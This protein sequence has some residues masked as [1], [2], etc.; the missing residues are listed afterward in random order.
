ML[1]RLSAF[2]VPLLGAASFVQTA[3]AFE[4]ETV[5]T[6]ARDAAASPYSAPAPV[7]RFMRDLSYND[8]QGIRFRTES[9]L[10]RDSESKF[11]VMMV[12]PGLFYT[13][14][15]RINIIEQGEAEPLQFEKSQ[16]DYPNPEIEK[17]VP[18]DLGYAGLKVTFPFDA[19]DV[20][21]Q[22][23]V[24]AGA[25]YFRAVGK[26]NNFGISG[27]GVAVDT[28]LPSGEE[29]PAFVEFWLEKPEPG[30]ETFRLYGLLDGESLTGAYQFTV[31]PGET[32]E[33][34]VKSVIFPRRSIELLGL[35][36]LT[37]MF[38]YGENMLQPPGEWRPEVHDSDGLLI[39]DG[40]SDEWLWRPL[41]NPETLNTDYFATQNVRG[42]GLIQRDTEFDSYMDAEAYYHS[43]PSAWVEP[44]GDWGRGD[45]VLVQLPTPDETNDNIVS[46]WRTN[47]AIRPEQSLH[48]NYKVRFGGQH[49]AGET[50]ARA[51]DTYL[52]D[53]SRIGGGAEAGAVRIIVDFADGPLA[54]RDPGAA[55]VADVSGLNDT[56]IIEHFVEYVAPLDRWRLSVLARPAAQ[57]PLALRAYLREGEQTLSET[58]TYEVPPG[59]DILRVVNR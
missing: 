47:G 32:T 53:G 44:E 36:P 27:R 46:F 37:S 57:K 2:A 23:L 28:G 33:L 50:L 42:F 4:F 12:P 8:Y 52:G 40:A 13:H 25:S 45:V 49:V 19:P 39:H 59:T 41:R 10:W 5:I 15:V 29:F 22:F 30:D 6:Q 58:W 17:L 1:S 21:N 16:F 18:A 38:Y 35:A 43:R 55:V 14:P 9:S 7:P 24:F 48:F 31:T 54:E 51:V 20:M 11:K 26:E 34:A 56:E 3:Q